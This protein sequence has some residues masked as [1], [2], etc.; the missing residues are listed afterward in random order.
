MELVKKACE[1]LG[2]EF[3]EEKD[4]KYTWTVARFQPENKAENFPGDDQVQAVLLECMKNLIEAKQKSRKIFGV[5][6]DENH[7]LFYA[8]G[9]ANEDNNATQT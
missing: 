4:K 2:I 1:E 8:T 7:K 3:F 6:E 5:Y 9:T